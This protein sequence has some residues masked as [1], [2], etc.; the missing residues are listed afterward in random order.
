MSA[1][2]SSDMSISTVY[3]PSK[4]PAFTAASTCSASGVVA[5]ARPNV[6]PNAADDRCTAR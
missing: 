6:A 3:A 2:D 4:R 1:A 5:P